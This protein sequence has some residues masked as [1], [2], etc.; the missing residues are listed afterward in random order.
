[1]STKP[2]KNEIEAENTE[3][4]N[5]LNNTIHIL[6]ENL[7]EG[8]MTSLDNNREVKV[9]IPHIGYELETQLK[10]I[11]VQ[12]GVTGMSTL[13]MDNMNLPCKGLHL[14]GKGLGL[15][16]GAVT[17]TFSYLPGARSF[18]DGFGEGHSIARHIERQLIAKA[19]G[20]AIVW[21]A[22]ITDKVTSTLPTREQVPTPTPTQQTS[23]PTPTLAG[24][25]L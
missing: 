1:M 16:A 6:V 18:M 20:K 22:A 17:Q 19:T 5:T 24:E 10:N 4:V 14:T 9:L 3:A 8:Y 15:V 23:I 11:L 12:Q 25:A 7:L 2:T 21:G 13:A